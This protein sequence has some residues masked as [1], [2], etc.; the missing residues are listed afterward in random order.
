MGLL[1][2]IS[3]T[4]NDITPVRTPKEKAWED[5]SDARRSDGEDNAA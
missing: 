2:H 5:K 4:F 3:R 1:A